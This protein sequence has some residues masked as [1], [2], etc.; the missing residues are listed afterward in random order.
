MCLF[1]PDMAYTRPIR[2]DGPL[3]PLHS[4]FWSS[5]YLISDLRYLISNPL[6]SVVIYDIWC[7]ICLVVSFTQK[8]LILH[9]Q[10]SASVF[11]SVRVRDEQ[12]HS[13]VFWLSWSVN[14]LSRGVGKRYYTHRYIIEQYMLWATTTRWRGDK[15]SVDHIIEITMREKEIRTGLVFCRFWT[16]YFLRVVFV[17]LRIYDI[18]FIS[19]GTTPDAFKERRSSRRTHRTL[20]IEDIYIAPSAISLENVTIKPWSQPRQP[21]KESAWHGQTT[22][23][24][25][26]S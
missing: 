1:V 24:W 18:Y 25:F 6:I 5:W 20:E 26:D 12:T 11:N 8:E 13:C 21:N 14:N 22:A 3:L 15:N 23:A 19:P 17:L 10:P 2:H 7:L 4:D 16:F 9:V